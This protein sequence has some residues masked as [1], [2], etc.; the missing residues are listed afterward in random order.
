MLWV[1]SNKG[2]KNYVHS[3]ELNLKVFFGCVGLLHLNLLI[4]LPIHC[5]F[6]SK[7]PT[8]NKWWDTIFIIETVTML[9]FEQINIPLLPSS[10]FRQEITHTSV[11]DVPF[12]ESLKGRLTQTNL[13]A[14]LPRPSS[15]QP[16]SSWQ[17]AEHVRIYWIWRLRNSSRGTNKIKLWIWFW[18]KQAIS[19]QLCQ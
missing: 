17:E 14:Y 18:D 6:Q 8:L 19:H 2:L 12:I 16:Q 15:E 3:L 9:T 13:S 1:L 4:F 7:T 5:Q 10:H 11:D